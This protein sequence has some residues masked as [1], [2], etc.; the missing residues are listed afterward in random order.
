MTIYALV[1]GETP[2]RLPR[3]VAGERLRAVAWALGL[4]VVG[5]VVSAPVPTVARVRAHDRVVRGL[6]ASFPAVLPARFA[7][8]LTDEAEL[9][10]ALAG[11]AREIDAALTLVDGRE[12]MT[13]R[14]YGRAVPT[15]AVHEVARDLGA[16]TRHLETRRRE[17][18]AAASVPELAPLRPV[19]APLVLAERAERHHTP[20]L[21]AT[22]HHL[23]ERGRARTYL[24]A[25]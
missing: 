11:R 14:L 22:V 24:A 6:T 23:I 3:G 9:M 2:R 5:D 7:S 21:L 16:G 10:T 12:Q 13:L 1:R 8:V 18:R 25:V 4:A 19:L 20:P 17:R 15:R